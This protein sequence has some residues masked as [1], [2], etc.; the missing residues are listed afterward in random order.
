M[1]VQFLIN[2]VGTSVSGFGKGEL[3]S[4]G[5]ILKLEFRRS[6]MG[7]FGIKF[8]NLILGN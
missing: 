8:C 7:H 4:A 5:L 2:G 6:R 1:I 3:R